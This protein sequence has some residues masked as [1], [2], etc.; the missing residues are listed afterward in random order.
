[1]NDSARSRIRR[2]RT[3]LDHAEQQLAPRW[4]RWRK[5]FG[6][7]ALP[8]LIGGGLLGGFVL[9]ALPRK[10]WSRTGAAVFGGGAW[11]ARSPL[12]PPLVAALWT[13]ILAAPKQPPGSAPA[14]VAGAAAP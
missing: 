4:Q 6:E 9:A 5:W 14:H 11:L 13:T 8:V 3:A 7:P 12:G 2:A 1:M 10:W